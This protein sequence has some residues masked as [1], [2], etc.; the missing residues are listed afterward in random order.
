M[1]RAGREIVEAHP[2]FGAGPNMIE[3]VYPQF[4]DAGAVEMATSHLHNVPL[5]IAAERGLPALALWIWFSMDSIGDEL[6]DF[7][8]FEGLHFEDPSDRT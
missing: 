4:R 3:R 2:V 6:R 7:V 5:Q 1:M 8:S